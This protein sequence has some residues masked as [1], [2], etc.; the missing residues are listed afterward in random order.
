MTAQVVPWIPGVLCFFWVRS[1][2]PSVSGFIVIDL[3]SLPFVP[4][5]FF[6]ALRSVWACCPATVAHEVFSMKMKTRMCGYFSLVRL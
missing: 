3:I 1:L 4:Y 5:L 2:F 6:K